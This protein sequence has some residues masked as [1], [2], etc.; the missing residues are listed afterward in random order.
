MQIVL[1]GEISPGFA[2]G[3]CV[4]TFFAFFFSLSLRLR[5]FSV[6]PLAHSLV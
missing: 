4:C 5:L 3:A 1:L 2:F 6:L